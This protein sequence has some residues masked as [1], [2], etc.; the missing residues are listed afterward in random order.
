MKPT[1]NE[2]TIV[3]AGS[4]NLAILNPDWFAKKVF[5]TNLLDVELILENFSPRIRF[6]HKPVIVIPASDRV[7]FGMREPSDAA[8]SLCEAALIRLLEELP[9]TPITGV[10][11]NFG[12]VIDKPSV[13]LAKVFQF[14][15]AKQ[16]NDNSLHVD[17]A[18]ITRHVKYENFI[19]G[20]TMTIKADGSVAV[21]VNYHL[22]AENAEFAR[23]AIVGKAITC[24]HHTE[25]LIRAIYE[26]GED[27]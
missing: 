4:W 3:A 17:D 7:I 26:I 23:K 12:Y 13:A 10:G 27:E 16:F 9:V 14:Q 20:L 15:D 22:A 24:R 18:T 5:K 11:I 25:K 19:Y 1:V 21:K 8:L 6:V 2:W